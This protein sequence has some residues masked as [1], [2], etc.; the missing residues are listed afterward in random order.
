MYKHSLFTVIH[1][2]FFLIHLCY[3]ILTLSR[4]F[5]LSCRWENLSESIYLIAICYWKII[6]ASPY[7]ESVKWLRH[8]KEKRSDREA[9]KGGLPFRFDTFRTE[10]LFFPWKRTIDRT[11]IVVKLEE[12]EIFRP[13]ARTSS[14]TDTDEKLRKF[15]LTIIEGHL[16]RLTFMNGNSYFSRKFYAST[17]RKRKYC[18]TRKHVS[19]W[20][21]QRNALNL[22]YNIA[23]YNIAWQEGLGS[24]AQ[25]IE[26]KV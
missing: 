2:P 7:V 22:H 1:L 23:H 20:S 21:F 15:L 10:R 9:P 4:C 19:A 18:I 11:E 26:T 25:A 13:H 8:T 14:H 12:K 16:N 3:C 17:A 6:L 24:H 5:T